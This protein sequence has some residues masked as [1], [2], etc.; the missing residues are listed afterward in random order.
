MIH[1]LR[2][3]VVAAD[4]DYRAG[5]ALALEERGVA[6]QEADSGRAALSALERHPA[7]LMIIDADLPLMSGFDLAREARAHD[8]GGSMALIITTD[9]RWPA[10]RKAAMVRRMGLLDLVVKPVDSAALADLALSATQRYDVKYEEV[11][12]IDLET[13]DNLSMI[14]EEEVPAMRGNLSTLPLPLLLS[15]LWRLR[16]SGALLL[17][18]EEAKKIIYMEGGR[19]IGVRSNKVSECLGMVLV[20]EGMIS[21]DQCRES[22]ALMRNTGRQQGAILMEMGAISSRTL[23]VGLELQLKAKLLEVFG[24][25]RGEFHLRGDTPL[26]GGQ[27][28]L[29]WSPAELIAAGM[30]KHWGEQ[31]LEGLLE[32]YQN[33]V[34]AHNPDP[35]MRFQRLPLSMEEQSLLDSVDRCRTLREILS[36]SSLTRLAKL[37]TAGII[38]GT[39][40]VVAA[41]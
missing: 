18:G 38:L 40:V 6:V 26:P 35:H 28:S 1:K 37:R 39:S 16:A 21:G 36:A 19:P 32:P 3:I 15:E 10:P 17:V 8:G 7:H 2:G 22:L 9:V 23:V 30:E 13:N 31:R 4:P 41:T 34:L 20:R 27:I 11:E 33:R 29:D 25:I 5:L 24:W 12:C 14:M